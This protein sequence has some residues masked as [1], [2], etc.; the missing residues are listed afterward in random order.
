[1]VAAVSLIIVVVIYHHPFP[2]RNV[3]W[4]ECTAVGNMSPKESCAVLAIDGLRL[5]RVY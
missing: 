2:I 1:M 3:F 4:I 5:C